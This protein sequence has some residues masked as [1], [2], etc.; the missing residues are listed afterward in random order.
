MVLVYLLR[1]P[2]LPNICTGFLRMQIAMDAKSEPDLI[3]YELSNT[4]LLKGENLPYT[5]YVGSFRN[6]T[7]TQSP[8]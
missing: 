4:E 2:W 8:Y 5:D 6:I 3:P 7:T 1:S